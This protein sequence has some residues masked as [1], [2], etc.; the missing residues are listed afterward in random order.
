MERVFR[1]VV[2]VDKA[3]EVGTLAQLAD[4][5]LLLPF[6]RLYPFVNFVVFFE[7]ESSSRSGVVH[8]V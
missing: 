3:D 5:I 6:L 1:V 7:V 4:E 2:L 8:V